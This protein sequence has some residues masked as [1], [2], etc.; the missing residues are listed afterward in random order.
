MSSINKLSTIKSVFIVP[1]NEHM[2]K[3]KIDF[4]IMP[5]KGQ[6]NRSARFDIND[7]NSNKIYVK[8]YQKTD[9]MSIKNIQDSLNTVNNITSK[10]EQIDTNKGNISDNLEKIDGLSTKIVNNSILKNIK[11]RLFYD[12]KEQIDFE[13]LFFNKTIELNIKKDDFI[14]INLRMLLEYEFIRES[15]ITITE[16]K[17]YDD[18]EQIFIST[19]NNSNDTSFS[20]FV[21]INK[22]I[23]YNFKKDTKNLKIII[24]FRTTKVEVVNIWYLPKNIDRMIVKHYGN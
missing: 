17:L 11:N 24:E 9:E 18:N 4:F 15:Q 5:I 21:Y 10:L 2:T 8:Y 6:E 13:N 12:E 14:E 1:I 7:I 20:N 22:N 16:F 23:F 3:I 19:Y